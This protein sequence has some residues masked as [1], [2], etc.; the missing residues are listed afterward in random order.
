MFQ[1]NEYAVNNTGFYNGMM[2]NQPFFPM[3]S[4]KKESKKSKKSSRI[5]NQKVPHILPSIIKV[6]G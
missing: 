2:Y 4:V 5:S 3:S 6:G 1:P